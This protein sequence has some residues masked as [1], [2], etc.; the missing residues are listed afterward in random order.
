M[1]IVFTRALILYA[2]VV[3]VMRMMGKRQ[4]AEMQ[5][6]ELVITIMIADLAATPMENAGVPLLN[7]VIPIMTLLSAQV[8]VSY[9]S[10]KSETF[11]E[12]VCGKPSILIDKGNIV[13]SEVRRLRINMNDLLE[14]LRS[15]NYP[16]LSDVEFAILE[17]NGQITIIPKAEKRNV[18]TSDMGIPVQPE[19]LPIT[20]IIDGQLI[21]KNLQKTG[22]DKQWLMNQLKN[23]NIDKI[24]NVFF[25]FLSSEKLF[26]AQQKERSS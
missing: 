25:G 26:Y 19:E 18:I 17:T 22:F 11:R 13:Q 5:P 6:F 24:E 2:L 3:V 8:I 21:E 12:I 4:I 7:G 10:L 14:Q 16:N 1:L 15:K 9:L 20:L 23:S